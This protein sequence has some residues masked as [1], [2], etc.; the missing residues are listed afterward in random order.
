MSA[1]KKHIH[2]SAAEYRMAVRAIVV[3]ILYG[4]IWSNVSAQASDS[5]SKNGSLMFRIGNGFSYAGGGEQSK[6]GWGLTL[7]AALDYR[8]NA[9]LVSVG[10]AGNAGGTAEY[11]EAWLDEVVSSDGLVLNKHDQ[12]FDFGLNIGGVAKVNKRLYITATTG[13][14]VVLA[15]RIYIIEGPGMF[16]SSTHYVKRESS[17]PVIGIPFEARMNYSI[18]KSMDIGLGASANFNASENYFGIAL[19]LIFCIGNKDN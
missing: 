15:R 1:S 12:F 14:S 6:P 13:V 9:L 4:I 8:H 7:R 2:D 11:D 10:V 18:F 3:I 16:S 5:L 17:S 19:N